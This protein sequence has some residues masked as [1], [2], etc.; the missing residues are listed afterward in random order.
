[1]IKHI[2]LSTAPWPPSSDA[3]RPE[4]PTRAAGGKLQ[5]KIKKNIKQKYWKDVQLL[6]KDIAMLM[7]IHTAKNAKT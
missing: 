2:Y 4:R 3:R 5:V 6:K 7:L 1:M